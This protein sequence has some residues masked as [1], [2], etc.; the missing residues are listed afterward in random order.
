[1]FLL[2]AYLFGIISIEEETFIASVNDQHRSKVVNPI[3]SFF[4]SS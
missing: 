1:M 4:L 2:V 3:V